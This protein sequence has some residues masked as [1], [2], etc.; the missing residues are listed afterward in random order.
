M[1]Q[2]A[3]VYQL[4]TV[5]HWLSLLLQRPQSSWFPEVTRRIADL[6]ESIT[7]GRLTGGD[8]DEQIQVE[9]QSFENAATYLKRLRNAQ[10]PLL[11]LPPETLACIAEALVNVWPAFNPNDYGYDVYGEE[12]VRHDPRLYLGWILFGHVCSLLRDSLLSRRAIWADIVCR[13]S[14]A[15]DSILQRSRGAPLS[16]T[17]L[18]TSGSEDDKKLSLDFV[19]ERLAQARTVLLDRKVYDYDRL[20]PALF[21]QQEMPY[22]TDMRIALDRNARDLP[23][24]LYAPEVL[25]LPNMIAPRLSNLYLKNFLVPFPA[26]CLRHLTLSFDLQARTE[27]RFSAKYFVNLL[28]TCTVLE[29][30]VVEN[31]LP[32]LSPTDAAAGAQLSALRHVILRDEAN[33][34]SLAWDYLRAQRPMVCFDLHY[35]F[36]RAPASDSPSNLLVPVSF[37]GKVQS[38]ISGLSF[39]G[40]GD[41][42]HSIPRWDHGKNLVN[43]YA[44]SFFVLR[45]ITSGDQSP[46]RSEGGIEDVDVTESCDKHVQRPGQ[47]LLKREFEQRLSTR[48][49]F[50]RSDRERA[51]SQV[52]NSLASVLDF[53]SLTVLD[54]DTVALNPPAQWERV[55]RPLV[56][57]HSL[58]LRSGTESII[59][60]LTPSTD[61]ADADFD[62]EAGPV[63][64]RLGLLSLSYF[65][66]CGGASVDVDPLKGVT[67]LTRM[68]QARGQRDAAL[69]CLRIDTIYMDEAVAKTAFIPR[70]K[71]YVPLVEYTCI[72]HT[73]GRRVWP[74]YVESDSDEEGDFSEDE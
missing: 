44:L 55:L 37:S 42:R 10:R 57:V 27:L 32:L 73:N 36:P 71:L 20:D 7:T 17:V 2:N 34:V 25:E 33:L 21:L 35:D 4:F 62:F 64:P 51:P 30:L 23:R 68:L 48:F 16:L 56:N 45:D 8:L 18:R 6:R 22:L 13:H 60:V 46:N 53:S 54:L 11:R 28:Q 12:I 63:L 74:R 24:R 40:D 49:N 65:N 9:L 58:F 19:L 50:P 1:S 66:L 15:R 5:A 26:A 41:N 67:A 14:K 43:C 29:T 52:L 69:H 70:M 61:A 47:Q 72:K 31:C 38:S 3:Y 59:K 39:E